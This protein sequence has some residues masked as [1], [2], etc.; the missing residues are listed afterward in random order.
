MS[1]TN[2]YWRDIKGA[3]RDERAVARDAARGRLER[4]ERAGLLTVRW[5][6]ADHVRLV[7]RGRRGIQVDFWPGTGRWTA[8]GDRTRQGWDELMV[9]LEIPVTHRYG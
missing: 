7:A 9:Y 5:F 2:E 1:E 4:L 8:L 3:R 6:T